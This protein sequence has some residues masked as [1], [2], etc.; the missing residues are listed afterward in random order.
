MARKFLLRSSRSL[1]TI[2]LTLLGISFMAACGG[3]AEEKARAREDSI[4]RA[5]AI[6]DSIAQLKADSTAQAQ[7]EKARLDSNARADSIA[8]AKANKPNPYKPHQVV[9]KYGIRME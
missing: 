8:K 3:N 1:Y 5:K 9:T 4:A 7:I 6:Q 2:V